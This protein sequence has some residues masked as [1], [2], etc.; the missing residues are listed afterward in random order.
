LK[1]G[2]F[3]LFETTGKKNNVAFVH[4]SFSVARYTTMKT[5]RSSSI[6]HNEDHKK[7]GC[8]PLGKKNTIRVVF[9]VFFACA[10]FVG[11]FFIPT[12]ESPPGTEPPPTGM[13]IV[14][15]RS[16]SPSLK[17]KLTPTVY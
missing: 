4:L 15:S 9:I 2:E 17:L 3:R 7:K 5:A 1:H 11:G 10:G 14:T 8:R 6:D 16:P 13:T 12:A